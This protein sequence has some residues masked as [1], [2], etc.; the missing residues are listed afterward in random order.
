[1]ISWFVCDMTLCFHFAFKERKEK[2]RTKTDM[3]KTGAKR[4]KYTKYKHRAGL[5]NS[6]RSPGVARGGPKHNM[7][8]INMCIG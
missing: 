5:R 1:M 3:A 2:R 8:K 4:P 7:S 6:P